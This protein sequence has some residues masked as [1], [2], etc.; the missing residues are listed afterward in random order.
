MAPSTGLDLSFME[1]LGC[2]GTHP[3]ELGDEL[4]HAPDTPALK[5]KYLVFRCFALISRDISRTSGA[6]LLGKCKASIME[7]WPV[8]QQCQNPAVRGRFRL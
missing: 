2:T 8:L 1:S 4:P 7:M 5:W 3:G 6:I